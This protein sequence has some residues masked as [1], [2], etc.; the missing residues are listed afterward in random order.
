MKANRKK[1][2]IK[3]RTSF[4]KEDRVIMK[5][6]YAAIVVTLLTYAPT[7]GQSTGAKVFF[8]HVKNTMWVA[9]NPTYIDTVQYS[10][11]QFRYHFYEGLNSAHLKVDVYADFNKVG[12][13]KVWEGYFFKKKDS[14]EKY[15]YHSLGSFGQLA[16]GELKKEKEYVNYLE[17]RNY[18]GEVS[19]FKDKMQF[20]NENEFVDITYS[21]TKSGNWKEIQK[22]RWVKVETRSKIQSRVTGIGGVFFKSKNPKKLR[23]WYRDNLGL[24]TDEWGTNFIW[25]QSENPNKSGYTQWSPFIESTKYFEPSQKEFM[26]NYRVQGLESM[27]KKLRSKG[28]TILDTI[29]AYAYGKFVHI[30]DGEGNKVELWE[31]IDEEYKRLLKGKTF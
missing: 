26:I 23:K 9:K 6:M 20:I 21:K 18:N 4:V 17:V 10:I 24:D 28:V 27:I 22:L 29:K 14:V 30:L 31:P 8:D 13:K 12:E 7:H 19:A 2:Q 11:K 16:K 1:T 15:E 3:S 5:K 25:R